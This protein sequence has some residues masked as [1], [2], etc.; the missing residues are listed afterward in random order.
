MI[1]PES[2]TPPDFDRAAAELCVRLPVSV[3]AAGLA[4]ALSSLTVAQARD[5]AFRD[6]LSR[7]GWYRL[8]GVFAGDGT[9]I[10]DDLTRWGEAELARF[11]DDLHAFHDAYAD[12]GLTATRLVGRTHYLVAVTGPGTGDF[13]QVEV[14][15][16]QETASH[17]LF[18]AHVPA[19]LEE[20]FGAPVAT[21]P[22]NTPLSLPFFSYRR[23]VDIAGLMASIAR[24]KP[25]AQPVHRFLDAWQASS[26]GATTHFSNHWVL[27]VR[28][29]LDRYRQS[30]LQATPVA[31]LNGSPP[32]F[33]S[34]YGAKGLALAESLQRFDRQVGYPMAWFFHML[35]TKCVPQ[36]V[37]HAVIDDIQSGFA[38]LPERDVGVLKHW[39]HRPFAF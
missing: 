5:L 30:I 9:R 22:L 35:T 12:Q 15:E 28:D 1:S 17:A 16:L 31:A 14:E 18:D 32:K 20:L 3:G 25:E 6:V 23:S 36:A 2:L 24:Q 13:I 27:A 29:Y 33:S 11:D 4:Q 21:P 8:G 7:G 34:V 10:A 26:A 37:A 19:S 38:Y 39:L